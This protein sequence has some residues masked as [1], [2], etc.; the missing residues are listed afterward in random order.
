MIASKT[1]KDFMQF[2]EIE[3]KLKKKNEMTQK[4]LSAESSKSLKWS[5]FDSKVSM[6]NFA[7]IRV[8]GKGGL[9]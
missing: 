7:L 8:L 1:I 2:D 6:E 5:C 3:Q 4:P 9:I